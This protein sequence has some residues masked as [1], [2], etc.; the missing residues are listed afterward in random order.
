M[1]SKDEMMSALVAA[2]PS[3]KP[4][5]RAFL[6]EW[7]DEP[8]EMP[9]YVAV[10]AFARHLT[11]MLERGETSEF[12]QIFREIDNLLVEGD[13]YVR[14]AATIG[15]LEPLQ[16]AKE[17]ERFR[18]YLGPESQKWWDKLNRFWDG[19]PRSLRE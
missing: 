9:L 7:R 13:A 1:I 15:I 4:H 17:P 10:A 11:S 12:N 16:N 2:C 14:E 5:W 18:H 19:D 3:F 8:A 6:Q